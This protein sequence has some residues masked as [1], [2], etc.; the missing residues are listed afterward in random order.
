MR[1]PDPPSYAPYQ[2]P[3]NRQKQPPVPRRL[4]IL[5]VALSGL[6]VV[7]LVTSFL[8]VFQLARG[9]A[10]NTISK[11][12]ATGTLTPADISPSAQPE[13]TTT[14]APS[15]TSAPRQGVRITQNQDMRPLCVEETA[16]YTVKLTN[17]GSSAAT[18]SI[19]F[20][21]APTVAQQAE[22]IARL[23]SSRMFPRAPRAGS[24]VWG[25]ATPSSGALG[26]GQSAS[27]SI[28]VLWAMPCGGT[29]YH[30]SVKAGGQADLPLT[31]A[32]TGAARFSNII[33]T[34]NE[35]YT[36]TCPNGVAPP[37]PYTVTIKNTGN[38]RAYIYFLAAEQTPLGVW[39]AVPM[40]DPSSS[41][42]EANGTMTITMTP[43]N[44]IACNGTTYNMRLMANTGQGTTQNL[45]LT[46]TVN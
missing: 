31:Y 35:Q 29:T 16:P 5:A 43:Q 37:I 10:N 6:A 12:P 41:W 34:Q 1:P 20:P 26:P 17:A 19:V 27:F 8:V 33:V 24:P 3:D 42:I 32:G 38:Y 44:W 46:D 23:P 4:P 25:V 9:G 14:L 30:A 22:L 28:N 36:Q 45:V 15:P 2:W 18:W 21:I 13:E 7:A 11:R 39:W 40:T